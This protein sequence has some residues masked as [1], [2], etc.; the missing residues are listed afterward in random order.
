MEWKKKKT[1]KKGD[2]GEDIVKKY[3]ESKGWIV[4]QP[5]TNGGHAFDML[6]IKHKKKVIALDVKTKAR[7]N[8]FEATGIDT[9]H[10]DVYK[11]IKCKLNIPFY[12]FFVD[13][14]NGTVHCQELDKLPKPFIISGYLSCWYLKDMIHLFNIDQDQIETL[15][16]FDTRSYLFNPTIETK[17]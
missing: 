11:K 8:K 14:K 7:F 12:L 17:I 10:Y 9:K 1:V 6:C 4:Y 15:S 3:M 2:L 16:E 13:D 5:V